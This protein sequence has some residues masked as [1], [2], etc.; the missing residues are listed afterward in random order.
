MSEHLNAE[1]FIPEINVDMELDLSEITT[2]FVKNLKRFA[3]FGPGNLAPIF[4]SKNVVEEGMGRIVGEKHIKM[5]VLYRNRASQPMDAIAFNL[6][7]YF[8]DISAKKD[9]DIL[10]H[11][12]ENTWNNSTTIQLNVKDIRISKEQ[13]GI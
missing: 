8:D 7:E 13:N 9:F 1:S 5:R 3:P 4:L 12:E 10:Y 6:K 11:V 2:D